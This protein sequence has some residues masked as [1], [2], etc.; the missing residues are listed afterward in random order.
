MQVDDVRVQQSKK[1]SPTLIAQGS[2]TAYA[3]PA[4]LTPIPPPDRV[5]YITF[6][7]LAGAVGSTVD[8]FALSHCRAS[9]DEVGP[10]STPLL[11]MQLKLAHCGAVILKGW[12][13]LAEQLYEILL[14][15]GLVPLLI[16]GVRVTEFGGNVEL[17]AEASTTFSFQGPVFDEAH[18]YALSETADAAPAA[19][20]SEATIA[21]NETTA[22][23]PAATVSDAKLALNET[24]DV[25]PAATV[26]QAVPA[27][28]A[29]SDM[30]L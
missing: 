4:G 6:D 21:L 24:K 28:D 14:L 30:S 13:E 19:T 26:Y 8:C 23:A 11:T 27:E 3:V 20:V 15:K 2:L 7:E 22:D 18:T 29:R 17:V 16:Q 10:N 12:R 9:L 5:V 1:G 25:A